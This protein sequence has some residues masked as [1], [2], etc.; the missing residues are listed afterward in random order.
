MNLWLSLLSLYNLIALSLSCGSNSNLPTLALK[1]ATVAHSQSDGPLHARI[2]SQGHWS[3]WR[4]LDNSGCDD[5]ES[6]NT[7]YFDAFNDITSKWDAVALYNCATNGWASNDLGYYDG[8]G[9]SWIINFCNNIAGPGK[10]CGQSQVF[11]QYCNSDTTIP[12][13]S[14]F[15]IDQDDKACPL[16]VIDTQKPGYLLASSDPGKPSC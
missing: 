14:S 2:F 13:Y 15:W 5:L 6:G 16:V 3:T 7:D 12:K 1:T 11:G 9:M 10:E 4:L 8:A